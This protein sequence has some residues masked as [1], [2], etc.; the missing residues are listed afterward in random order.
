MI[1]LSSSGILPDDDALRLRFEDAQGL[2]FGHI[3]LAIHRFETSDELNLPRSVKREQMVRP[4]R[5]ASWT[6]K[7]SSGPVNTGPG[8]SAR[9]DQPGLTSRGMPAQRATAWYTCTTAPL[10][11]RVITAMRAR[12]RSVAMVPAATKRTAVNQLMTTSGWNATTCETSASG[13]PA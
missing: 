9:L 5:N 1:G 3:V 10:T 8:D 6:T 13:R 11:S 7:R 2:L 12:P 4:G